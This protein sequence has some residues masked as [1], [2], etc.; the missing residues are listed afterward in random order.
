MDKQSPKHDPDQETL[1][2]LIASLKSKDTALRKILK[3]LQK[4]S[5][6]DSVADNEASQYETESDITK[7]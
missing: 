5:A 6:N 2:M 1:E 3:K 4:N 7:A